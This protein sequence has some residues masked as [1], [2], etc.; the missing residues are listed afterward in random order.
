M[1]RLGIIG[2]ITGAALLC[3]APL[4]LHWSPA[5]GGVLSAELT[6][7]NAAELEIQSYR[8]D[9]RRVIRPATSYDLYCGGP[10]A[11]GGWNGGSYYGG[12]WVDLWCFRRHG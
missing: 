3:M 6:S 11:G 9:H 4:S 8:R 7:A 1:K 10:Y 12:P 5:N 2:S